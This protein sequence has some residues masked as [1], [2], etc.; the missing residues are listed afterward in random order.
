[1]VFHYEP[2]FQRRGAWSRR[3]PGRTGCGEP[4]QHSHCS[5]AKYIDVP[6]VPLGEVQALVLGSCDV[7]PPVELPLLEAFGHV[8]AAAV[9][10]PG[11]VPPFDNTAMD[12]FAVRAA[13]T[14]GGGA[15]LSVV[16]TIAAGQVAGRPVGPGQAMRI[17]TGA[18]M[19]DGADAIVMVEV[20]AASG[21]GSTV[22]VPEVRAGEHVRRAGSDLPAGAVVCEPPAVLTP[23]HVGVLASIGVTRAF[24][25]PR[26][27]VGVFSTGDELVPPGVEP[28][29]GQI[30]DSNRPALLACLARDGFEPVDLGTLPDREDAV[31]KGVE[32]AL[33]GCDAVLTSGGV[34]AG[35]FDYV[36][37]VLAELAEARGGFFRSLGVAI[38]P[39]KPFAFGVL[40]ASPPAGETVE[41]RVPVF[42]LPGNPVSS[43]VSYEVLARPALRRMAGHAEPLRRRIRATAGEDFTRT[44]DGKLHL[45]RV[46]ARLDDDGRLVAISAGGQGSHQLGAMA[47]AN[48]LALVPDGH[49]VATGGDLD[50]LVLDWS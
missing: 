45:D 1:M 50:L 38:R 30:R 5:S 9:V 18:P 33:T 34:S 14:S 49:G 21:D 35:D 37:V 27:R 48:A 11:D 2:T 12:G 20:A 46:A 24:V 22:V 32:E 19:P 25:H 17:M 36:K 44:P 23:G 26:P 8:L 3:P 7:L 4:L 43:L 6:L 28:E 31:R 13:D 16:G 40:G 15:R 47:A 39:A 42:G 29:K 41:R 10:A